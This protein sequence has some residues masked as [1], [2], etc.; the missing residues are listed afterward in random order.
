MILATKNNPDSHHM[1]TPQVVRGFA[2]MPI[3]RLGL[4]AGLYRIRYHV[5]NCRV[6]VGQAAVGEPPI[7][8]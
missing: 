5:D 7:V 1:A 3:D 6:G 2:H 8:S 4:G